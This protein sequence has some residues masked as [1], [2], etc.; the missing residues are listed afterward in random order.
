MQVWCSLVHVDGSIK[1]SVSSIAVREPFH[2]I[3]EELSLTVSSQGVHCLIVRGHYEV[4]DYNS[5]LSDGSTAFDK[6]R[7]FLLD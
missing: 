7:Q 5:V 1:H 6:V 4:A 2:A 3:L